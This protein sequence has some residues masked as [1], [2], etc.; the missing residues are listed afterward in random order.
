MIADD[1]VLVEDGARRP[2]GTHLTRSP[3]R[4]AFHQLRPIS[5]AEFVTM[6]LTQLQPM[7]RRAFLSDHAIRFAE[8]IRRVEDFPLYLECL[9]AGA[10]Y[11]V[12]PEGHYF[13]RTRSGSITSQRTQ[14]YEAF[15]AVT[16]M[17]LTDPRVQ[18]D[19]TLVLALRRQRVWTEEM[20]H[21]SHFLEAVIKGHLLDAAGDV[22]R[23]PWV[24][25]RFVQRLPAMARKQMSIYR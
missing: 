16:D 12:L 18:R 1:V 2:W 15:R 4:S 9:L 25:W 14:L 10:R 5:A 11:A 13:Y 3:F 21:Y 7:I 8:D 22:V 20:I 19:Q 17:F 6:N 24:V 23:R